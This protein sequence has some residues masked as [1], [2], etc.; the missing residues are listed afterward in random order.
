MNK[1]PVTDNH[2]SEPTRRACLKGVAGFALAAL[3]GLNQ[4]AHAAKPD[5]TTVAALTGEPGAM[6][7]YVGSR[8]TKERNAR[9]EGIN[10]Y[11]VD[12]ATGAWTHVQLLKDLVN[13]SFL[14]FDAKQRYLYSVHGDGEEVSAFSADE[15]SGELTFLNRRSCGGKNPVHLTVDRSNSHLMVANYA[16]GSL[17]TLPIGSDGRLG[18]ITGL[19]QLPGSPGP[20]KVEQTS[21][22]PHHI[23]YDAQQGRLVVPDKALDRVFVFKLDPE[24][25]TLVPNDPPS[26][27]TRSGAGPRHVAFHPTTGF[28]YVVNELDSTVTAY[29][30]DRVTGSLEPKQILTT[31]PA[32]FTEEN[33][34]AG[35]GITPSGKFLY[36]SNRGLNQISIFAIDQ[37]TGMLSS[38]GWE[39]TRGKTPRFFTLD[40]S[41]Q[42]LYAANETSD[43]IVGFRIDESTGKLTTI[44]TVAQTGSPVCIVFRTSSKA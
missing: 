18:E 32:T 27:A 13:P 22:H 2:S 1:R 14:A 11:R 38:V 30:Y 29:A 31:L 15:K 9:G 41:G 21:S 33:R 23:P 19:V 40:P 42:F 39:S 28:A 36:A 17:A 4:A 12:P 10:V 6:L 8:T 7:A 34:A 25:G 35:I 5:G 43:T 44:G 26:V 37:A 20:H 24:K 3:G 16:T